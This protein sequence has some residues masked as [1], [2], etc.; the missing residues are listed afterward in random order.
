MRFNYN[1]HK[2]NVIQKFSMIYKRYAGKMR[3]NFNAH[4][5]NFNGLLIQDIDL[6]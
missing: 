6:L 3:S 4:E 5:S 1:A 2:I